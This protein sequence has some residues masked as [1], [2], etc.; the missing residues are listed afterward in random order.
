MKNKLSINRKITGNL[1]TLLLD[2]RIDAYWSSALSDAVN[3]EIRSGNY[4]LNLDFGSV[5]FLS[6]A[7]IRIL[8]KSYKDL[9]K[10]NGEFRIVNLTGEIKNIIDMVGLE[11]LVREPESTTHT[12]K[13]PQAGEINLGATTYH[14]ENLATESHLEVKTIGHPSKM[15]SDKGPDDLHQIRFENPLFGLGIGAISPGA[16]DALERLGEFIALGNAVAYLPTDASSAPDYSIK[17]GRLIPEIQCLY[18]LFFNDSFKKVIHFEHHDI[19]QTISMSGLTEHIFEITGRRAYAM[20]MVAETSGLVGVSLTG[21][22]NTNT[23]EHLFRFPEVRDNFH[24]TIEP[25]HARQLAVVT[26]VFVKGIDEKLADFCRPLGKDSK[27]IGHAH[28]AV[29]GFHPLKKSDVQLEDLIRDCFENERLHSIM[30]LVN[31][32]RETVGIGESQFM[33]GMCW[34]GEI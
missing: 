31:D 6:S 34:V 14:V 19:R 15:F 25:E 16:K 11:M 27:I 21:G 29:F 1:V 10:I 3:T 2:G 5:D 9:K 17:T 33:N 26:G 24:F 22:D 28:A 18:G 30:H 12:K 32:T 8:I 4:Q 23:G 7:G 20:V 13:E